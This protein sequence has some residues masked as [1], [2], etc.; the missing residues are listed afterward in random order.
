MRPARFK[1]FAIGIVALVLL[2]ASGYIASKPPENIPLLLTL[3]AGTIVL[4][5][6]MDA[7]LGVRSADR[8]TPRAF[9]AAMIRG[10]VL[11]LGSWLGTIWCLSRFLEVGDKFPLLVVFYAPFAIVFG[12]VADGAMSGLSYAVRKRQV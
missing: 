12:A 3:V 5:C 2:P 11:G 4:L 8:S 7:L 6:G 10:A 9:G 1:R